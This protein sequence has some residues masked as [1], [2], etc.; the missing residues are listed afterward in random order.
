MNLGDYSRVE[1]TLIVLRR[2][3]TRASSSTLFRDRPP[4]AG[5]TSS[6]ALSPGPATGRDA[7]AGRGRFPYAA[8]DRRALG[9]RAAVLTSADDSLGLAAVASGVEVYRIPAASSTVFESR[10]TAI[11]EACSTSMPP[12][13]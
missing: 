1:A 2:R 11:G 7:Y 10:Y 12:P 4:R 6:S 8:P 9:L 3:R 5:T 13:L